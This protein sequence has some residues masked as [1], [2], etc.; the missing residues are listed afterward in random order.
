MMTKPWELVK[1]V[2]RRTSA[3][4]AKVESDDSCLTNGQSD[5]TSGSAGDTLETRRTK[6][7]IAD[8]VKHLNEQKNISHFYHESGEVIFKEAPMTAGGFIEEWHRIYKAFPNVSVSC[9]EMKAIRPDCVTAIFQV[10]GTH[11]GGPYCFGPF[12]EIPKSGIHVRLDP[13]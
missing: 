12:P 7:C 3:G 5:H 11:T 10:E 13:E 8:L 4:P 1:R 2:F 6:E 9:T